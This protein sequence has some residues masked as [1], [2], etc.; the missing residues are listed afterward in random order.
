MDALYQNALTLGRMGERISGVK[1]DHM[2]P[3]LFRR[4]RQQIQD[5]G[6]EEVVWYMYLRAV[7]TR[8]IGSSRNTTDLK[9]SRTS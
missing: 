6:S 8:Y 2:F 5:S 9:P 1:T 3:T 7:Q 4:S